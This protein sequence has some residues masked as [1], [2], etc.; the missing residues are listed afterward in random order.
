MQWSE[1]W[2]CYERVGTLVEPEAM[3]CAEL[4]G[5]S[6]IESDH[7]IDLVSMTLNNSPSDNDAPKL[8]AGHGDG[9]DKA[10]AFHAVAGSGRKYSANPCL[11]LTSL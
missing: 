3:N 9:E 2:K 4:E 8:D 7:L 6:E 10:S 5:C 1:L 11:V